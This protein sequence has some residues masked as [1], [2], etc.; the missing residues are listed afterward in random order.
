[1]KN[2]AVL[3]GFTLIELIIVLAVLLIALSVAAPSFSQAIERRRLEAAANDIYLALLHARS[4]AIMQN[5]DVLIRLTRVGEGQWCY[6]MDDDLRSSSACNCY[7]APDK[8]TIRG[9][10]KVFDN[11]IQN[12]A[13]YPQV[14]LA[15]SRVFT[16]RAGRGN[17]GPNTIT[18][19][20]ASKQQ[21]Y[22]I[23]VSR[24][25]RIRYEIH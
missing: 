18:L 15:A 11:G 25:G 14:D 19:D 7:S 3:K 2:I 22:R 5:K 9:E 12:K 21:Q 17:V 4:Q 16:F 6:G 23:I 1:V 10:I 24:L 13:L 8:C 20:S